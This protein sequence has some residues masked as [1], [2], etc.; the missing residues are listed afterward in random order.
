MYFILTILKPHHR[1]VVYTRDIEQV[2][3][4]LI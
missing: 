3:R 2:N 1:Q 4:Y